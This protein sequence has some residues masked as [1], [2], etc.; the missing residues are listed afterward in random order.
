MPRGVYERK[1]GAQSPKPRAVAA[2]AP[3][4]AVKTTAAPVAAV[5]PVPKSVDAMSW[6]QLKVYARSIGIMQR[7]VDGLTEDRL[8][9]NCK[10]VLFAALED[11]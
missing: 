11:D 5:A 9:Q 1:E 10:A 6:A 2:K 4:A 8:R 7:D 3:P